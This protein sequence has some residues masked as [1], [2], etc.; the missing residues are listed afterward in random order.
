MEEEVEMSAYSQVWKT[1]EVTVCLKFNGTKAIIERTRGY[2]SRKKR[3]ALEYDN[4]FSLVQAL[5]HAMTV[6][7]TRQL[8]SRMF[9]GMVDGGGGVLTVTWE[10]YWFGTCNALMLRG[11]VGQCVA[12][13]QKYARDFVMWLAMYTPAL[14]EAT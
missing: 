7:P 12:V 4:F 8:H 14:G 1:K 11:E 5:V 9:V 13:E 6:Q 3:V 2:K 10:P